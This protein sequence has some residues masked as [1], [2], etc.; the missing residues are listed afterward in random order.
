MINMKHLKT[1]HLEFPKL[2]TATRSIKDFQIPGDAIN[3]DAELGKRTDECTMELL[4]LSLLGIAGYGFLLKEM[5]IGSP[6]G[7]AACQKHPILLLTGAGL[8]AITAGATLLTRE[9][10]VRCST[11]QIMILRTFAKIENGGWSKDENN[12]LTD[13]INSFRAEQRTKL[14]W[15]KYSLR[16]AHWS[17]TLGAVVTV[18]SFGVVL[19]ALKL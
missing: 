16:I 1:T 15:T 3:A 19:L 14:M 6:T 5:A 9:W 8:L 12:E 10:L 7:L 17:L 11:I 13:S 18:V 2:T 4:R